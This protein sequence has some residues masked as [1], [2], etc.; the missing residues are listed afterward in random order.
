MSTFDYAQARENMVEQQVRPWDVLD[1]RV[2]D[3][4]A[5]MPREAFVAD[6]YRRLAYTDMALPLPHGE[7]MF[8]PVVEGRILQALSIAPGD[9][10]LDIGSGSGFL[11]ACMGQLGRSVLGVE[12]HADMAEAAQARIHAQ[13]IANTRVETADVFI[14]ETDARFDVICVGGAVATIPDRFLQWLKPDGRLFVVHGRV[15]AMQAVL[16]R[17]QVNGPRI[18]SLFETELPYL[19]GAAPKP[20]FHF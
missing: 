6:A 9:D 13:G 12:R 20:E 4:L 11:T 2:L 3:V 10:V 8:K 14:W 5:R 1:M 7:R 17:H 15:P 19:F 18:E 16:I